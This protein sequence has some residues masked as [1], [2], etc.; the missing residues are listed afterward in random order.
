VEIYFARSKVWLLL[1][2]FSRNSHPFDNFFGCLPYPIGSKHCTKNVE[3]TA[4]VLFAT[5]NKLRLSTNFCETP[6]YDTELRGAPASDFTQI[7]QDI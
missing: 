5:L 7:S 3:S 6:N 4:K 1:C 2:R